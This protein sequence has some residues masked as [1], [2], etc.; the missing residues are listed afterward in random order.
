MQNELIITAAGNYQF[1][2]SD[3]K[4]RTVASGTGVKGISKVNVSNLPGG[5]YIIQLF[6]DNEKQ[7][8]RIIKQ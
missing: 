3:I 7:T 5:M 6:R 8:E 1:L 2:L 4:G